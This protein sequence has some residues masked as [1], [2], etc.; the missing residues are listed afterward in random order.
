MVSS[1]RP[2]PDGAK[3]S[4]DKLIELSHR[5]IKDLAA[6][7]PQIELVEEKNEV[8]LEVIRQFQALLREELQM[9]QGVRKKIQSQRREIAE[10]SAEWDILFR[11]YYADEMRKLGVG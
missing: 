1:G 5:I 6:M 10:G 2:D 11:K 9:D 8:R 3:L 4:R 7:K